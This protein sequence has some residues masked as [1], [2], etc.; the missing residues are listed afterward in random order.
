M[1]ELGDLM[2]AGRSRSLLVRLEVQRGEQAAAHRGCAELLRLVHDGLALLLAEAAYGLALLLISA[3]SQAEA[4]AILIGLESVPG[5]YATLKLAADLRAELEGQLPA[6]QRTAAV[7]LVGAQALLQLLDKLCARKPAPAQP[8]PASSPE[9]TAPITT[10]GALFIAETGEILS[11]REIDV[12]RLLIAG[13]SNQAIADTLVISLH[14]VKKH[15][16]SILKKLG[17]ATRTQAALRGRALGLV[18][19]VHE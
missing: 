18:P 14:T 17:V 2:Y 16:A 4:L 3:G 10:V 7:E 5:E 15:V 12:V 6:A 1:R 9:L 8:S 11:P 19:H 13:V